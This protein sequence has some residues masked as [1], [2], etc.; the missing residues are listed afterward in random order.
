MATIL[1]NN[2]FIAIDFDEKLLYFP[3]IRREFGEGVQIMRQFSLGTLWY[4][5]EISHAIYK[6]YNVSHF[7][8]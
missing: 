1:W 5:L 4:K 7:F 6:M 8:F 2:A 3:D